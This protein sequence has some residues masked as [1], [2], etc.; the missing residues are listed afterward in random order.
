MFERNGRMAHS[1]DEDEAET[2][3]KEL[4]DGRDLSSHPLIKEYAA[5][6]LMKD[7]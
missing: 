7:V 6:C 4:A 3:G 2:L 5:K 1:F